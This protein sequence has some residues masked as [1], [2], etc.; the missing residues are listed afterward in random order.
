MACSDKPLFKCISCHKW[1]ENEIKL[2]S[3]F[4]LKCSN[5]NLQ[6][7]GELM[8]PCGHTENCTQR[9]ATSKFPESEPRDLLE[10]EMAEQEEFFPSK[11]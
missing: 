8:P 3:Y 2:L 11:S 7:K 10:E 6:V 5:S 4:H 9:C 1:L